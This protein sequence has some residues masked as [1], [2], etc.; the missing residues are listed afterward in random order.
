MPSSGLFEKYICS[1]EKRYGEKVKNFIFRPKSQEWG[2]RSSFQKSKIILISGIEVFIEKED[3]FFFEGF[4]RNFY[5]RR[6][7]YNCAFSQLPRVADFTIGDFWGYEE[8]PSFS[9]DIKKGL[10]CVIINSDRAESFFEKIR[11]SLFWRSENLEIVK[12]NN[13]R[14]CSGS[15]PDTKR[16][17]FFDCYV[18]KGFEQ[19]KRYVIKCWRREDRIFRI[20]LKLKGIIGNKKYLALKR[21]LKK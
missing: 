9:F 18:K 6:S 10:S 14:V 8:L 13:G 11:D 19:S 21:R 2:K 1:L 7:C 16:D 12:K 15:M 4:N 20:K 17:K 5:L 3:L